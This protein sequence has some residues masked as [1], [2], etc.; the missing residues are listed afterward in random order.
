MK[1]GIAVK[2]PLEFSIVNEALY[3]T[4][5]ESSHFRLCVRENVIPKVLTLV[6]GAAHFGS[7]IHCE[8]ANGVGSDSTG[9]SKPP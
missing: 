6:H 4:V 1:M 7:K 5:P 8:V 9:C 3:V 2:L